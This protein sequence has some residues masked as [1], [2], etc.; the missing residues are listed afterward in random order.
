M[1]VLIIFAGI[2]LLASVVILSSREGREQR[3]AGAL[4]TERLQ[5][6]TPSLAELPSGQA[7]WI[8]QLI[9]R[10]PPG[11]HR[12]L[13]RADVTIKARPLMIYAIVVTALAA[14]FW[15][16]WHG[17]M[18][19]LVVIM[20]G[21]ILPPLYLQRLAARRMSAF[22]EL[23]PHYLDSIRQL[24]AVGNSFQQALIK[25]TDNAGLPVQRYLQPAMRRIANGA[26]V[27]DA[28]DTVA[29]RIDLPELYMIVATVRTNARFGGNVGPP[30]AGL[31]NLLRSRA[32]VLRELAAASAE[33][34]MS[35]IILC[36]L[37]PVAMV[38]ISVIN[39]GYMKYLWETEAGRHLLMF[40]FGFQAL[41]MVTM[42][43]L[44][45]LDF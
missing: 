3:E 30:L 25:S 19:P 1:T 8:G 14:L 24:L 6:L 43:R 37:P 34:R 15:L 42:R 32:R 29:E 39:F 38:L 21:M 17:V 20:V 13:A 2:V 35:A 36:A 7:A 28:I 16:R 9:A 44:M 26:P 18:A 31:V 4:L 27:P 5:T 41:G 12:A 40:G 33:T 23:L 45:R 22:V 11:F 10:A